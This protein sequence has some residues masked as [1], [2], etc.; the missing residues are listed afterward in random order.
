MVNILNTKQRLAVTDAAP[1]LQDDTSRV[2]RFVLSDGSVARDGHTLATSGWDTE[3]Y[4]RNPVV[5]FA[6]D[7]EN[8]ES[9]IGKMINI[10]TRGDQLLGDVEF[11]P[12]DVNPMAETVFQ[13]VKRKFLNAVSVGFIPL[14]GKPAKGRAPGDFDFTRQELLEVSVV[15]VPALATA[16]AAGRDFGADVAP[17]LAWAQRLVDAG[18]RRRAAADWK[19]G[20]SKSLPTSDD[21]IWDGA[22]AE[23]AILD[24]AADADGN[25]DAAKAKKGFLIYDAG[26]SSE[27]G[28]YKE[29][30]ATIIDG[31]L[32]VTKGGVKAA[33]SRL[34]QVDGA[35]DTVKESARAVLDH[36]EEKLGMAGENDR[37][38]PKLT[39]RGL[40][41]VATLA[42]LVAELGWLA[43][44]S[45]WEE[46]AEGDTASKMPE[47]LK[48]I[49][50]ELGQALIDMTVEEVGELLADPEDDVD[51]ER[52]FLSL[53]CGA[54]LGVRAGLIAALR[55][56]A[57]GRSVMIHTGEVAHDLTRTGRVL[58]KDNEVRL[59][60]A[61]EH[62]RCAMESVR[63]V[64]DQVDSS[65]EDADGNDD[66]LDDDET[67][68]IETA[69]KR[70]LADIDILN[71]INP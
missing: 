41:G 31:K 9:V 45:A 29:P 26:A 48:A 8:V 42:Y 21:N 22:A 3:S 64:V 47:T 68:S 28:S 11:M 65:D 63:A 66:G 4:R 71:L 7:S 40:Y 15:P 38:T 12:G 20:A 37:A 13:M 44:C 61:H 52:A 69:R 50:G 6:H 62:L 54:D 34:P 43:D 18:V 70:A 30:F 27:R 25:I 67:R 59:R 35:S 60:E 33:A 1:E 36:Y 23:K 49:L 24:A 5:L 14:E 57:A 53:F 16:L 55:H 58:S 17:M 56:A 51:A 32:T 10:Q 19:C 2:V 46:A 39:K